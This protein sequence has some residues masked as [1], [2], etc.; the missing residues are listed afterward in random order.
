M[1]SDSGA[2]LA[3]LKS[4]GERPNHYT[5]TPHHHAASRQSQQVLEDQTDETE[6]RLDR[7]VVDRTEYM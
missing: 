6:Y 5:T 1:E 3:T 4:R 2:E 7:R